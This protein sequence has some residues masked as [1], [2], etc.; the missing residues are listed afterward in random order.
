M[1]KNADKEKDKAPQRRCKELKPQKC[2]LCVSGQGCILC[3]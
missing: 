3:S 1:D 2:T